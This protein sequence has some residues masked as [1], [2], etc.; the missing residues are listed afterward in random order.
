MTKQERE[1]L[2]EEIILKYLDD[3]LIYQPESTFYALSSKKPT[4][5]QKQLL[6]WIHPLKGSQSIRWAAEKMDIKKSSAHAILYNLKKRCP[7]IYREYSRWPSGWQMSLYKHL[8]PVFSTY[9][10]KPSHE[11]LAKDCNVSE[12][13]I[14]G[15]ITRMKKEYP[16]AFPIPP[17]PNE[18]R[19]ISYNPNIHDNL[20]K[21]KF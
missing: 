16:M 18:G 17:W 11:K 6:D 5:R 9:K 1:Q 8:H 10:Y 15:H 14:S 19:N 2:K 3:I 20:V 21:K 13:T 4:Y 12:R 7:L